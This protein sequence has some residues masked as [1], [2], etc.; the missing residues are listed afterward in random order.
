MSTERD[1]GAAEAP[2]GREGDERRRGRGGEGAAEERGPRCGNGE[3]G[4]DCLLS[5]GERALLF[6]A[7]LCSSTPAERE[8]EIARHH[9]CWA[10]PAT[11]SY[12]TNGEK[13][14]RLILAPRPK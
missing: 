10:A 11:T 13:S 4:H 12:G 2:A 6:S 8:R 7:L 9:N 3:G 14:R 5:A 1:G